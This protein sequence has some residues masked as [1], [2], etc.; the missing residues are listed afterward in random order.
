MNGM[1]EKFERVAR[2]FFRLLAGVVVCGLLF[3][4]GQAEA[5]DGGAPP[6]LFSARQYQGVADLLALVGDDAAKR[7]DLFYGKA[8]VNVS[9]FVFVTESGDKKLT[10]LGVTLADQMVAGI[11]NRPF[12][13]YLYGKTQQAMKGVL[14]E[15]DGWL[16]IHISGEN[17]RGVTRSYSARVEMSEAVYRALHAEFR[18]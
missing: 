8:P 9:P 18:K 13:L 12:D 14:Q 17:A 10:N 11:N 15:I 5:D 3:S 1:K 16:R 4:V 2:G 7:F 6:A